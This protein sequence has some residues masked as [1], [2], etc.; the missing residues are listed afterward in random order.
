[1][2]FPVNIVDDG[3]PV[4]SSGVTENDLIL[5]LKDKINVNASIA[6]TA[7]TTASTKGTESTNNAN[8]ASISAATASTQ[9]G[10]ATTQAGIA[11]TKANE[12]IADA[13]AIA[14]NKT[15]VAAD[16]VIVAADKVIVAADKNITINIARNA[17]VS[18][19]A[20]QSIASNTSTAYPNLRPTIF[21]DFANARRVSPIIT[22]TRSSVATYYDSKGVVQNARD[23]QPRIDFNP[24]TGAC[25][26]LLI[27]ESRTNLVIN[28]SN[29]NDTSWSKQDTTITSNNIL[30]PDGTVDGDLVTEGVSNGFIT[31]NTCTFTTGSTLT[32]SIYVKR[33]NH[34][35]ILIAVANP[36]LTN[37]FI[38]YFNLA[39]GSF[40]TTNSNNS[41]SFSTSQIVNLKNGWYRIS[42]S[43]TLATSDTNAVILI[44]SAISDNS[45]TRVANGTRYMWGAQLEAYTNSIA[46]TARMTSYIPTGAVSVTRSA[47]TATMPFNTQINLAEGTIFTEWSQMFVNTNALA[48][49][50]AVSIDDN[51]NANR[52]Y[53]LANGGLGVTKSGSSVLGAQQSDIGVA[54]ATLGVIYKT[55]YRYKTNDFTVAQNGVIVGSDISG[56]IPTFVTQMRLGH[57]N[58]DYLNGHILR[59]YCYPFG[60]ADS[61]LQALTAP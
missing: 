44:R 18:A 46:S 41:G 6:N 57:R 34:D 30:S 4:T 59:V 8:A 15:I 10:I 51:S 38:G 56:L 5:V 14:S 2:T 23:N 58:F 25:M 50:I 1:M 37:S 54:T 7:A 19:I 31:S 29:L 33:G 45:S 47:D 39:T 17:S 40:G 60:L 24:L 13:A 3:F 21:F 11:T 49:S 12:A 53:I 42:I 22:F 35:W 9:L 36:N 32:G 28:S 61:Q 27:E 16:K 43:G 55:A 48:R 20:A 52:H 26:G